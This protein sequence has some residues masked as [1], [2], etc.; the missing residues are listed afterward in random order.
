MD[1]TIFSK[2]IFFLPAKKWKKTPSKGPDHLWNLPRSPYLGPRRSGPFWFTLIGLIPN[3]DHE[4]AIYVPY[5][6]H[7][8]PQLVYFLPHFQ[9]PL[10]CFLR[11]FFQ[12]FLSL[13]MACIQERLMMARVRYVVFIPGKIKLKYVLRSHLASKMKI[14]MYGNPYWTAIESEL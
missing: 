2:E 14:L 11:R 5:A 1:A 8:K 10:L 13:C 3:S 4:L 7:Y 12:K 9:R 6:R